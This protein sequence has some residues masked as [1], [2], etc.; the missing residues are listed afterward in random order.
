MI[1]DASVILKAYFRDETGQARPQTL[2]RAH[3]LGSIELRGPHLLVYE[4]TNAVLQAVRRQRLS[5]ETAQEI[6]T[7]FEDLTIPLESV[8]SAQVLTIAHRFD[9]SAYDAAYLALAES[10][11]AR[12]ITGDHRLYQAVSQELPWE[13]WLDE[14]QGFEGLN[15]VGAA[16]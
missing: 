5:L 13:L 11:N 15:T 12:L 10:L 7:A 2:I 16:G 4:V 6:L 1:V 8:S 14:Y 9:R 3:A